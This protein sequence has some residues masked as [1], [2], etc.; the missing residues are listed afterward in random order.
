MTRPKVERLALLRSRQIPR[1]AE[2]SAAPGEFC[3][4]LRATGTPIANEE[5]SERALLSK[6]KILLLQKSA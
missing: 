5:I 6:C 1:E 4:R 2:V 3:D